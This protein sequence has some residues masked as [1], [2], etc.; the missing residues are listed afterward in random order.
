MKRTL[1]IF[2]LLFYLAGANSQDYGETSINFDKRSFE[3]GASLD[4]NVTIQKTS[5]QIKELSDSEITQLWIV[6]GWIYKYMNFDLDKFLNGG[7]AKDIE[8][9]L[10]HRTGICADYSRL[11]AEFCDELGL[12]NFII[13]GYAPEI[14][15][16]NT[17]VETNHAWNVVYA[18][19]CWHHCDL[20]GFSGKLVI[21]KDKDL[22][23]RKQYDVFS[24]LA[25]DY[26]FLSNHIPADP[27]WQFKSNP[28]SIESLLSRSQV[29]G[30]DS[31]K[32]NYCDSIKVFLGLPELDKSIKLAVNAYSYNPDNHNIMVVNFYNA[33]VDLLN[34]DDSQRENLELAKKYLFVAKKHVYFAANGVQ[35]LNERIEEA[36]DFVKQKG[37]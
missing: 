30:D 35:D 13:E 34:A 25:R 6:A 9:I 23:F 18:G 4:D 5:Q 7:P 2:F 14:N 10:K 1:Q 16:G 27:M 31:P 32:F 15:G 19:G 8:Y 36:L 28:Q 24:F 22:Y 20:Q 12:Q 26:Y 11:F 3:I 29:I 17:F 33:A 21:S 37:L